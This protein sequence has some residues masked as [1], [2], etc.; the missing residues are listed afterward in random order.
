MSPTDLNPKISIIGGG[1]SS[2]FAFWGC[3]DA[4]Y[5]PEEIEIIYTSRANPIG[6]VFMYE[7][8]IPWPPT[9]VVSVLIGTPDQYAINQWAQ[10]RKTSA[11]KRFQQA[12]AVSEQLYLYEEMKTILWSL[13]PRKRESQMLSNEYIDDLKRNRVAVIATFSNQERKR[14]YMQK[15]WAIQIPIYVNTINS[16]KH[17][18]Y[19]NGFEHIPWIRQTISQG[20]SYTEYPSRITDPTFIMSYEAQRDSK[21]GNVRLTPDLHP[22]CPDLEWGERVEGNLFRVGRFAAFSPGYLSHMARQETT[23]FLKN[24]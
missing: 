7:T 20:M 19:Y 13:I 4:N 5:Q 6:A 10:K 15:N 3:L 8:P 21:D 22:D 11:H 17:V 12:P 18:V 16:D 2:I 1:L 24:L 14:E 9:H 23:R